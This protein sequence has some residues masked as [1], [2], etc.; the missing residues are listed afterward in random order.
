MHITVLSGRCPA[1]AAQVADQLSLVSEVDTVD[2]VDESDD[3]FPEMLP[4]RLKI[5]GSE[6][7]NNCS[8]KEIVDS[9]HRDRVKDKLK[10]QLKTSPA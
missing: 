3:I 10:Q 4:V 5:N 2:L 7:T 8:V 6:V 9:W 1:L